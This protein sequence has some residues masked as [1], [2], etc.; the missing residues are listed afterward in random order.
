MSILE[1]A[2]TQLW[3]GSRMEWA[4][5]KKC[6]NEDVHRNVWLML[7]DMLI[8]NAYAPCSVLRLQEKRYLA[9]KK[10]NFPEKCISG[11][12]KGDGYGESIADK[13]QTEWKI[14][15]ISLLLALGQNK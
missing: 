7:Y 14:T 15:R 3:Q 11:W 1:N 10:E 9:G 13:K 5:H 6:T 4:A 8:N 12:V 2:V